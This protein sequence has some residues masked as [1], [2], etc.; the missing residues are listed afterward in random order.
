MAAFYL[1]AAVAGTVIPYYYIGSTLMAEGMTL[2]LFVSEVMD[3]RASFGFV[4]DVIISSIAF[5]PFLFAEAKRVRI[6][7]A[8][9][10]VVLN[11][12]VGLSCA[13]PLFLFFR[14]RRM[15]EKS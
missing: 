4:V 9:I 15:A 2:S 6:P 11:L 10:F 3:A 5:W 1:L 8:W 13:L 7:H 12:A 14:E